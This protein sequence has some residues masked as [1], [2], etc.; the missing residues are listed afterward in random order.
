MGV[1]VDYFY[2]DDLMQANQV[3]GWVTTG[4]GPADGR[5]WSLSVVPETANV[6][7]CQLL[8]NWW[9][10]DNSDQFNLTAFFDVKMDEQL[11]VLS[12]NPPSYSPGGTSPGGT[13]GLK[14]IRAP[15]V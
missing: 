6:A 4:L 12:G 13:F 2:N 7:V 3:Q 14:I 1:Q 5:Y 8:D 11:L 9:A 10:T 15:S